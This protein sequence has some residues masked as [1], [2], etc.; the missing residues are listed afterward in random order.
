MPIFK[1]SKRFYSNTEYTVD[2][3]GQTFGGLEIDRVTLRLPGTAKEDTFLTRWLGNRVKKCELSLSSVDSVA[4]TKALLPKIVDDE[5]TYELVSS[6][7]DTGG[8]Q[9]RQAYYVRAEKN[10]FSRIHCNKR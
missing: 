5:M 6:K 7:L 9:W 1:P 4:F 8:G 2:D 3:G 10:H